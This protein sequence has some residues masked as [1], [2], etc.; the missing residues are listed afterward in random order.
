MPEYRI[1]LD[2]PARAGKPRRERAHI[3]QGHQLVLAHRD[4]RR[5]CGHRGRIHVVQIDGFAQRQKRFGAIFLHVVVAAG[6]QI[7]LHRKAEPFHV[8]HRR[9]VETHRE[10]RL[11][12]VGC[13]RQR[14]RELESGRSVTAR[15]RLTNDLA[16]NAAPGGGQHLGTV[17]GADDD[18]ALHPPCVPRRKIERH[19]AA[20]RGADDGMQRTHLEVPDHLMQRVRLVDGT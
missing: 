11:A 10:L 16:L 19:H 4:Q 3:G 1:D 6:E 9:P 15:H 5:G 7:A 8:A 14:T 17:G 20:V 13:H 18:D 12:A 2:Q